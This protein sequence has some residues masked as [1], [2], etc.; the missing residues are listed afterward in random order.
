MMIK[1]IRELRDSGESLVQIKISGHIFTLGSVNY[2]LC[3]LPEPPSDQ[4]RHGRSGRSGITSLRGQTQGSGMNICI[5]HPFF[6][7]L[8][9]IPFSPSKYLPQ[10]LFICT[11][12]ILFLLAFI[13]YLRWKHMD[14][15]DS[16]DS[17]I[18]LED[19]GR[20]FWTKKSQWQKWLKNLSKDNFEELLFCKQVRCGWA[21]AHSKVPLKAQGLVVIW[22]TLPLT[23][24]EVLLKQRL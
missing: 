13:G 15:T 9:S 20:N 16:H 6:F 4:S 23:S 11:P 5:A 10:A 3:W 1:R 19:W 8:M 14:C 7:L 22:S 18:S 17:C 12:T 2:S 21:L 24:M